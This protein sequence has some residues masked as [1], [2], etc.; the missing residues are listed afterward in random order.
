MVWKLEGADQ[1]TKIADLASYYAHSLSVKRI[2]FNTR[3]SE[4]EQ[5][6]YTVATCASDQTVRI[7]KLTL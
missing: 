6:S 1:W 4:E 3:F 2:R 7:F 5:G